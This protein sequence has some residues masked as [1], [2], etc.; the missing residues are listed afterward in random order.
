MVGAAGCSELTSV[1]TLDVADLSDMENRNGAHALRA[2]AITRFTNA[3][4][5]V[6]GGFSQIIL[7]G[8][9]SD[10]LVS[11]SLDFYD[12]EAPVLEVIDPSSLNAD[13]PVGRRHTPDFAPASTWL[14]HPRLLRVTDALGAPIANA[15]VRF[16][17]VGE[18]AEDLLAFQ[19]AAFV[20]AL[21]GD[22]P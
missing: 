16:A 4:T 19:P 11:T 14:D 12:G 9:V 6:P 8:R 10:E 21:F 17:G 13:Q 15:P 3:Y 18:R 5:N 7:T 20:A 1:N 22:A 2:G